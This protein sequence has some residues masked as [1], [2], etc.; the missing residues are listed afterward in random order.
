[1]VEALAMPN[2]MVP[3]TEP[4]IESVRERRGPDKQTGPPQEARRKWCRYDAS[5]TLCRIADETR[6]ICTRKLEQEHRNLP[7]QQPLCV[8]DGDSQV[9]TAEIAEH[10]YVYGDDL[11]GRVE[12][13]AP[14]P[15]GRCLRVVNDFVRQDIA[16]VPLSADW[17]DQLATGEPCH[18]SRQ[19]TCRLCRD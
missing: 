8:A 11:A 6:W 14:R 16:D 1:M 19:I 17:P 10:G 4:E 7:D 9:R 15:T 5:P 13:W 12:Q 3:T 18:Q 2:A